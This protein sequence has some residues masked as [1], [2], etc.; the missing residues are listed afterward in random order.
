MANIC[1]IGTGYVGLSCGSCLSSMGHSVICVDIDQVKVDML[2]SGQ[3]PIMEAGLD[4]IV[5]RSLTNET[6]SFTT[7]LSYGLKFA[8]FVFLCLATPQSEDGS[9]DLSILMSAVEAISPLVK[10]GS[11]VIT[12]ST[13]PIGTFI[14]VERVLNR[15][16]V[17]VASNPEFVREGSAVYDFL[18]P[19]RIVIG[20]GDA[21]VAHR[22]ATIFNALDSPLLITDSA[23]AEAIKHASNSFLAVKLSYINAVA[24]MCELYGADAIDVARGIGLDSRIGSGF[25]APGPGWGGSCFPKDT[26]ALL[27]MAHARGY[28]FAILREAIAVNQAVQDRIVE[29]VCNS[30]TGDIRG[31][32]IAVW[33]L[34]FKANTD[35]VRDSPA[36]K[37][38]SRLLALGAEVSCYDPA[39][40]MIPLMIAQAYLAASVEESCER[41]ELLIVLTEWSQFAVVQPNQI[42]Q[43][44]ASKQ[45]IDCRNILDKH[46]WIDAG[47]SYQGLG[48]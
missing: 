15:T 12:K 41:A 32:K 2:N 6:L 1:V 8:E 14:E 33:G 46:R 27:Q 29:K 23:S 42:S 25:L 36:I 5:Q 34:T 16:D 26:S 40:K 19:D 11:V 45:I 10:S 13:V 31:K 39:V 24:I 9:A 48:R 28:E 47:F 4:E 7:D 3:I 35:D 20:S 37:I 43:K 44:M 22:V 38:I 17:S 18:H 21:E 30:I